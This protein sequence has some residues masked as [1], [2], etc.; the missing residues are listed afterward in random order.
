MRDGRD[1]AAAW[2]AKNKPNDTTQ[3][4]ALRLLL[5]V[6]AGESAKTLEP[7]ID[8]FLRRQN[9]DGGWGQLSDLPSDAYATGQ[10]L[11]VLNLAGVEA[12]PRRNPSRRRVPSRHPKGRRLVA[13]EP[14]GH[15][16]VTPGPYRVPDHL[17]RQ[18]R[19]R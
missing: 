19:R 2:L 3:A 9:K 8:Q 15:P 10:A 16:G 6:R 17:L 14:R 1:K 5:K 4:A 18:R 13:D 12:R 11:Y 7:D